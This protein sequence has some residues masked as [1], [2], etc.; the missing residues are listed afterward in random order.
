M[1]GYLLDGLKPV[2]LLLVFVLL[3]FSIERFFILS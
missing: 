3:C 1:A 2:L